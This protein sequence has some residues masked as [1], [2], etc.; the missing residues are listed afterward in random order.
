[1]AAKLLWQGKK[2]HEVAVILGVHR[3][4]IWRWWQHPE[5]EKWARWY[6]ATETGKYLTKV[7]EQTLSQLDDPDPLKA[8]RAAIRVLDAYSWM[9]NG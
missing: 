7:E 2:V 1:M 5:M 6:F 3:T 8:Q 9:W 4:T